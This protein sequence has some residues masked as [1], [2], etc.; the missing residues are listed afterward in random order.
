MAYERREFP[1]FSWSQSRRS[2]FRDCPRKY[3]WQYYGSHNGWED[4]APAETQLAYRLKQLTNLHILVGSI[5]HESASRAIL[6]ARGGKAP[7]SADALLKGGKK[8][9]N[10][11]YV[12][13][14]KKAD[15]ER[16]PKWRSMLQEFYYGT[17]PSSALIDRI[18]DKLTNCLRNLL[19]SQSY[20]DALQAPFVEVKS[21]DQ[22][23]TTFKLGGHVIYAQP[24]LLYRLG[25]GEWRIVDW[26]TGDEGEI[27]AG[28]LRIYGLYVRQRP[29]I[30]KGAALTGVLEYL[31]TGEQ[32]TVPIT[33]DDLRQQEG[34]VLDSIQAMQ[35]YLANPETNQPRGKESFP[36]SADL[37]MC[38][39]CN[40]FELNKA[41]IEKAESAG[42]F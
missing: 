40:F 24:D 17:G 39:Y 18:R 27:H 36:L 28:Q 42:P 3:Y 19:A 25:N 31:L 33:D 14:Q 30:E 4:E 41:E 35:R 32:E 34:E 23:M 9:L 16:N 5:V 7:Y 37:S 13:S 8:R 38:R 21:V 12:E 2:T 29:D 11:A 26:K 15:W 10:Q 6:D 22:P 20:R 1:E